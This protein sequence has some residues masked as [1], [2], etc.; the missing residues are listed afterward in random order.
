MDHNTN[1]KN[2]KESY[3]QPCEIGH[4]HKTGKTFTG[5]GLGLLFTWSRLTIQGV[6]ADEVRDFRMNQFKC[7]LDYWGPI[8]LHPDMKQNRPSVRPHDTV[9]NSDLEIR[10]V[11]VCV[12]VCLG[13]GGGPVIQTRH[14]VHHLTSIWKLTSS[15]IM[16]SIFK[17]QVLIIC[18]V[19]RFM[20]W[21][22]SIALI[23]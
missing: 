18:S 19:C 15:P 17:Y 22:A 3:H 14:L 20:F 9:P 12:C 8:H 16:S 5:S 4:R 21:C 7:K 13:G 6:I 23:T 11:C 2:I 10:C 1:P